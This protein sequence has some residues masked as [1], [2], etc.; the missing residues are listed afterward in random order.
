MRHRG[1]IEVVWGTYLR[2]QA[3]APPHVESGTHTNEIKEL[4]KRELKGDTEGNRERQTD[5]ARML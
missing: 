4:G 1:V 5:T 3:A 2:L